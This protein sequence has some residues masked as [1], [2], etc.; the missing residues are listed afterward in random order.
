LLQTAQYLRSN[1]RRIGVQLNVRQQDA[2]EFVNRVYTRRDFDTVIYG[3]A[4][5]PD[6]AIGSRRFYAST[7]FQPGI[8][9]SNGAHYNRREAD[10]LLDAAQVELDPPKRRALYL[11][12]Q[13]IVGRDAVTLPLVSYSLPV[14]SSRRLHGA[15]VGAEGVLG[16]FAGAW[17]AGS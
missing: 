14:I 13:Q 5:G 3:A 9:F 6:P 1:L 10:A 15:A 16:N 17:L 12:F 4:A 11:Q 8:A 7:N 2:G